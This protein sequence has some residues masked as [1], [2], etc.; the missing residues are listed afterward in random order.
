MLSRVE[1]EERTSLAL[2]PWKTL[3]GKASTVKA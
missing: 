1:E 2:R 3:I